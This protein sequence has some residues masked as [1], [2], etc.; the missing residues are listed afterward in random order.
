MAADGFWK[1][2]IS[3]GSRH[4]VYQVPNRANLNPMTKTSR[5]SRALLLEDAL[6]QSHLQSR[7]TKFFIKKDRS[8][9]NFIKERNT[10]P[11]REKIYFPK[12][13]ND[14]MVATTGS[15]TSIHFGMDHMCKKYQQ[16]FTL[17]YLE[18]CDAISGC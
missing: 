1:R 7:V 8:N 2:G 5:K 4:F 12:L 17:D 10:L 15:S 13:M 9:D 16:L 3:T 18:Q 14:L 11:R 6:E